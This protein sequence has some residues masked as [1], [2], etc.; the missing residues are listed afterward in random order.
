MDTL[1]QGRVTVFLKEYLPL[2]GLDFGLKR[3]ASFLRKTSLGGR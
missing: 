1:G 2:G 3:Q